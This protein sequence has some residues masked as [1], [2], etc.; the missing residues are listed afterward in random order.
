MQKKYTRIILPVHVL[1]FALSEVHL[2]LVT[3]R[4]FLPWLNLPTGKPL[5]TVVFFELQHIP[6]KRTAR[7]VEI[8][9]GVLRFEIQ[10]GRF[11]LRT[12]A[13][14]FQHEF[15]VLVEIT[16]ARVLQFEEDFFFGDDPPLHRFRR[17][18]E[19]AGYLLHG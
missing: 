2:R 16:E 5:E 14:L 11:D 17:E 19:F 1:D 4:R 10:V 12:S 6:V 18:M 8:R 7:T 3:G 13:D 15:L 9:K